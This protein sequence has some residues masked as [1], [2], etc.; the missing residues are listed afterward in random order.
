M[1]NYDKKLENFH[2]TTIDIDLRSS[3]M[4]ANLATSMRI[5][6]PRLSTEIKQLIRRYKNETYPNIAITVDLLTTGIDVPKI[7]HLV[8]LRRVKSRILYEQMLGR[9]TRRCDEIGKT[10][11]K[12][13]DPVDI[14]KTLQDVSTMKP[15]VKD[16]NITLEQL[17]D[18]LSDPDSLQQALDTPGSIPNTSHADDVLNQLNQKVMR[19]LRKA[20]KKAETNPALKEK[21]D[22]LENLWGVTPN[23]LHQHLHELGPKQ[24]AG[25]IRTQAGLLNQLNSVK[26]LIGS[27]H[28]PIIHDEKDELISRD[29][30][31]GEYEKPEDYL[32]GFNQYIKGAINDLA[33]LYAVVN[34]PNDLTRAELKEVKMV[35]DSQ[36]FNE[37]KLAT[38]W[39]NQTNQDI[40]ASIVGHIR[41]AA[42]GEPLIPFEMRVQRAMQ[43]IYTL[44]PW[45]PVQRRWLERLAKQLVHEVVIDK[46]FINDLPAF[47]GGVKQLNKVLDDQLDMVL[48]QLRG[49]LWAAS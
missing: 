45:T 27:E 6:E 34:R 48:D 40:A 19:V 1:P 9:A 46:Q 20:E 35:L 39:R 26:V 28:N 15:I 31:Y 22:E 18:E 47:N 23:K 25:F 24:S 8:F 5:L 42:I 33:A 7:A 37:A 11:F 49:H 10:V 2:G 12:V 38:A 21:L 16:P 29:Q 44:K 13:Y 17:V 32:E 3:S 4:A 43:I 14:Y 41:Q 30:T 36:G